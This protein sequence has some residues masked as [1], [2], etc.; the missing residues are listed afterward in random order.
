MK[1]IITITLIIVLQQALYA[2]FSINAEFRPRAE[3]RHGYKMLA[4]DSLREDPA[5][6]VSQRTR[7]R[8]DYKANKYSMRITLHNVGTW[9]EVVSK[10]AA[11][12]VGVYEA[13]FDMP[14]TDSIHIKI[15]RQE[16]KYDNERLQSINNWNQVGASHDAVLLY[17]VKNNWK[18]DIGAA[19]NQTGTPNFGNDYSLAASNY[20]SLNFIWLERKLRKH[21]LIASVIAD[22]YQK[23]GTKS[24]IY[25]RYTMG[26]GGNFSL[27]D[28]ISIIGRYFYQT[29]KTQTG[30]DISAW[31][32]LFDLKVNIPK[33]GDITLGSDFMS[34]NDMEDTA[35]TKLN[36]FT[37]LYG[38]A[39]RFNGSMDYFGKL[40]SATS[41]AGLIDLY[42]KSKWILSDKINLLADFHYFMLQNNLVVDSKTLNASL[43][44]E[45]DLVFRYKISKEA[46]FDLGY[47]HLLA[48]ATM[49]T[50]S[51]G[52]YKSMNYFV[53]CMLTF[54]PTLFSSE[55]K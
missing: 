34:G 6:F 49:E 55:K 23:T 19:W 11:A 36:A 21:S 14:L 27:S 38:S 41:N 32:G 13:W 26:G 33:K 52:D 10:S 51:G 43:G 29:G 17:Y 24:T 4:D 44:K 53:Y 42:L 25:M 31:H 54:K 1:A 7:L 2:Q 48:D 30:Q 8:F 40:P 45:I 12:T 37:N 28:N 39:H 46:V 35:N 47:S 18:A 9:G 50:I 5:A 22:G 16:L 3:I 15:G 20:K